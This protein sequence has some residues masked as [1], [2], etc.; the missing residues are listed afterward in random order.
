MEYSSQTQIDKNI[1]LKSLS[2]N[3]L[4]ICNKIKINKVG[5]NFRLIKVPLVEF[6]IFQ[7]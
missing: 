7:A 4:N 2:D 5:K 3:I 6:Y 1:E